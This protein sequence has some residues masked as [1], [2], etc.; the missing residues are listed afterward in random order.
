M[1]LVKQYLQF[2]ND[3]SN[4]FRSEPIETE[5]ANA[6]VAAT[7]AGRK[8]ILRTLL[9]FG[10]GV[11][12]NK[13]NV[14]MFRGE[15]GKSSLCLSPL[16]K[17]T[18]HSILALSLAA[19]GE[20]VEIMQ[21]LIE[22]GADLAFTHANTGRSLLMA[23]AARCAPGTVRTLIAHGADVNFVSRHGDTPLTCAFLNSL[24]ELENLGDSKFL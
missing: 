14:H 22:S 13:A 8:D 15:S 24:Q 3:K 18:R 19:A 5:I 23:A 6:C 10:D 17:T 16:T 20:K 1:K 21:V 4:D 7:L 9:E 2:M 12:V 11:D